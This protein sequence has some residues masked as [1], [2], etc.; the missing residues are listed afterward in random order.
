[1]KQGTQKQGP[2][3]LVRISLLIFALTAS[4]FVAARPSIPPGE[5]VTEAP[6]LDESEIVEAGDPL[7]DYSRFTHSNPMH[8]RLPCLTC[9]VRN[10]NSATPKRSSGHIPCASCHVEQFKDSG[11]AICSVCHT[12]AA[13]GAMK[14]FPPIRSFNIRFDHA[15]HLRQTNCATCHRPLR[16]GTALSVP[17]GL[18]AHSNCYQCHTAQSPIGSCNTCHQP[19]RPVRGSDDARAFAFNFKHDDHQGRRSLDCSSCHAVK[20]GMPR[21]RQVT[22]PAVSMHFAP[23]RSQSCGGCHNNT[24]AFGTEDFAN[25][26]RCHEGRTFKF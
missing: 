21:G 3:N 1:M 16:G 6:M 10:D 17:T 5:P 24:R 15:R 20:A 22:S 19:G 9:H 2:V 26:K 13:T 23:P 4:V 14:R 12:N 8:N 11:N 18:T 25:C 7:Q